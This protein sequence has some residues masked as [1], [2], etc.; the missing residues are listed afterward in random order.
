MCAQGQ[1][2]FVTIEVVSLRLPRARGESAPSADSEEKHE[3]ANDIDTIA[4]DRLKAHDSKRPIREAGV[5]HESRH[6][7]WLSRYGGFGTLPAAH[8]CS[9]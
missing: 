8:H 4:V 2:E 7:R 9:I 5:V 6:V 3:P 1:A